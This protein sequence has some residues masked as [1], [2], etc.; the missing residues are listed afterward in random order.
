MSQSQ[1][2]SY[3]PSRRDAH[4]EPGV[5]RFELLREEHAAERRAGP[6]PAG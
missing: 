4:I 6:A 3:T 1:A 5:I 2:L